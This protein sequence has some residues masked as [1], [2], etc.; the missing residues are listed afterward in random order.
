MSRILLLLMVAA[1]VATAPVSAQGQDQSGDERAGTAA[2]AYLLVPTTARTASLAN[3]LTGGLNNLTGVEAV[4]SNPAGLAVNDGTSALFS[5]SNYVADIGINYFGVA[6][7][8]GNNSVALSIMNW[9]FGEIPLTTAASSDPTSLT[10]DASTLVFGLSFARQLTDRIAAG[11]TFKTISESID[12]I[13]GN[14]I[15]F[16]AGMTYVVGE[17]GLRFGVSLRNFG[18][19]M[20]Y[21][22]NGLSQFVSLDPNDQ[23]GFPVTVDADAFELPSMLNFGATYTREFAGDLSVSAMGNFRSNAYE[24]PEFAGG[25]ELSFQNLAYAR[26][27]ANIRPD[28]DT[29]AYEFWSV[30][31]G[32]NLDVSG[33]AVGIDYAYRSMEFFGGINMFTAALSL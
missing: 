14:A 13:N 6:Q 20:N 17:S 16:D 7:Q 30:G 2:A 4:L 25:L 33:T 3:G 32:L 28:M 22:G 11:V 18:S 9:D 21:G 23:T 5:R 19:K 29:E 26:A 12:D 10:F 15:A 24:Q 27:G 1:L 8:F 31:A